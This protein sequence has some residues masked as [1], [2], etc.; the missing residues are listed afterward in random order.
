M[1]FQ[2]I[3]IGGSFLKIYNSTTNNVI[4]LVTFEEPTIELQKLKDLILQNIDS[5]V[6]YIGFSSQM[7]GFVLFDENNENISEF[8]TWKNFS[9]KNILQCETFDDFYLTGLKKRNDL[10]IN[11]L[12]E[13]IEKN[14]LSGKR[15][16]F[17]N[18]TEALLDE[19]VDQ[20]HVTMACGSGFLNILKN[21]YI[22]KH[23]DYFKQNYDI[24]LKFDKVVCEKT[25]TGWIN[26]C[27]KKIPVY[28]GLGDFQ[29]SMYASSFSKN[30]LFI[31]MATGSQIAMLQEN[32]TEDEVIKN[33][34]VFS[35]RPYF[36]GEYTKCVTHIPSG[37]FLNIF[38]KF[39][40]EIDISIWDQFNK[41]TLED[42][43]SSNLKI[44]T[45]IFSNEGISIVNIFENNFTIKNLMHS[46]LREF[47]SQYINIVKDNKLEF[48]AIFISGGIAKKIPIIKKIFEDEFNKPVLLNENDDDSI[49]GTIHFLQNN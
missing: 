24:D 38:G 14:N 16:F 9:K 13:Y 2:I 25:I 45:N 18:I 42:F 33:K 22:A 1:K 8:I 20:T 43:Q 12:A 11:N 40:N 34:N 35:Y 29:A 19:R 41:M 17:K 32:L 27:D 49:Y 6:D 48:D 7:H 26:K 36:N 21:E 44:N 37:R 3:D 30:I 46:V 28:C 47:L 39:F 23:L 31:N 15:L 4:K 5:D 10:P